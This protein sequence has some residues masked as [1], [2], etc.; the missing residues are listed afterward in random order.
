MFVNEDWTLYQ[1]ILNDIC[2]RSKGLYEFMTITD[3]IA[4]AKIMRKYKEDID[5]FL[6][7]NYELIS[8]WASLDIDEIIKQV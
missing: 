5:N 2:E 6:E 8:Q 4:C 3:I 1:K 7:E